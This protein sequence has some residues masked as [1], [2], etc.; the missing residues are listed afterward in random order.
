M[1]RA[2]FIGAGRRATSAHYPALGRAYRRVDLTAMCELDEDRLTTTAD[3]YDVEG[4][5][6]DFRE[7]LEREN[8]EV[9]YAVTR[10]PDIADIAEEVLASGAH[11]FIEKPPGVG[12]AG[13]RA[14][15]R[16]GGS[17]QSHRLRG[18]AAPLDADDPN[19]AGTGGSQ[20]SSHAGQRRHEQEPAHR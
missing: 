18:P 12:S 3:E 14:H 10:P 6:S 5:Y 13:R 20:R 9:V 11:L 4:R 15:C 19:G 16:G 7:M 2:A 17:Q 1:V 8:P